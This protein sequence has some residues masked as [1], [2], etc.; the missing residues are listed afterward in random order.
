MK[1][2]YIFPSLLTL[3]FLVPEKEPGRAGPVLEFTDFQSVSRGFAPSPI[4]PRGSPKIAPCDGVSVWS[5]CHSARQIRRLVNN[6]EKRFRE[7]P[8]LHFPRILRRYLKYSIS[9]KKG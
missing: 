7:R 3:C 5:H 1:F 8:K 4:L 9:R 2:H 6:S